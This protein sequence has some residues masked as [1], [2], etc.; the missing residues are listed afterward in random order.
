MNG[1]GVGTLLMTQNSSNIWS[2]S[3]NSGISWF[4]FQRE[5]QTTAGQ[6][7]HQ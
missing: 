6:V 7:T 5:I 4:S 3:G 2:V 1:E